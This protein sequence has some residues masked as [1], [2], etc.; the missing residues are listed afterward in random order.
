MQTILV[1]LDGSQF[2][3]QV[4]PH[5]QVLA[6]VLGA[7]VCLLQVVSEIAH[8]TMVGD[9]IL[10]FHGIEEPPERYY[11]RERRVWDIECQ[12]AENYLRPRAA[13]LHDAGLD[14]TIEVRL[15]Q[16]AETIVEAAKQCHANFIAMTTHGAS[17][18][19]RWALGSIADKV[20]HATTTPLVLVRAR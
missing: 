15:G 5:V 18:L 13:Q 9:T 19:R 6:P 4:L 10:G 16:P 17:G 1:P 8:I 12:R 11:E 14:A 3:E 20:L 7:R 2:A